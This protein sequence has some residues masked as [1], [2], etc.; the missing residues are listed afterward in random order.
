MCGGRQVGRFSDGFVWAGWA[1]FLSM[2]DKAQV[3]WHAALHR[4]HGDVGR[5]QKHGPRVRRHD[6]SQ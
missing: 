2:S 1:T 3:C 6:V 5:R 4:A